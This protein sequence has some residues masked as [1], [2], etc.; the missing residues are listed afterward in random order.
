MP[1][2][3]GINMNAVLDFLGQYSMKFGDM[4]ILLLYCSK[5]ENKTIRWSTVTQMSDHHKA[6]AIRLWRTA[7]YFT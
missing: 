2:S 4:Y 6:K 3:L 7:C 5:V 1:G